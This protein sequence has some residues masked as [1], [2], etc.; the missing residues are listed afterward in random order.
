MATGRVD[1]TLPKNEYI[2]LPK[3]RNFGKSWTHLIY[4]EILPI[5]V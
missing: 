2:F 3:T 5:F 1:S 4:E